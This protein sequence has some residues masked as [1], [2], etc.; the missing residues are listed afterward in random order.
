M[1]VARTDSRQHIR[2]CT[3]VEHALGILR[4]NAPHLLRGMRDVFFLDRVKAAR[5]SV[6][7]RDTR[8]TLPR[9]WWYRDTNRRVLLYVS[10]AA[11]SSR[12]DDTRCKDAPSYG[13]DVVISRH[14]LVPRIE[15]PRR[16]GRLSLPLAFHFPCLRCLLFVAR[17]NRTR[18]YFRNSSPSNLDTY[19]NNLWVLFF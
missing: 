12:V 2:L 16:V 13:H 11:K 5:R 18:A 6:F 15:S 19:G 3:R 1:R 8:S 17:A 10:P 14:D 7:P 4:G 9:S